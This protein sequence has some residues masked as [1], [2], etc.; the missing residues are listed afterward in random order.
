MHATQESL[1][2][3][4]KTMLND[5]IERGYKHMINYPQENDALNRLV[6]EASETINILNAKAENHYL[7]EGSQQFEKYFHLLSKELDSKS[8]EYLSR[9]QEIQRKASQKT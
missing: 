1:K 5:V 7:K 3:A 2:R 9:L 4:I 8:L 6:G